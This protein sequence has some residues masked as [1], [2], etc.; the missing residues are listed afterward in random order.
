MTEGFK[1]QP[2]PKIALLSEGQEEKLLA[3]VKG[4]VLATVGPR[5]FRDDLPHFQPDEAGRIVE[6]LEQR[7][8]K[9][10]REPRIR[11]W[12]DGKRIPMKD[13]VQD[14]IIQGIMGMLGT[15]KGFIPARRVDITLAPE[16]PPS[17]DGAQ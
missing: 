12:L 4:V 14:I 16:A 15:L 1:K 2:F 8:L 13:F 6:M 10:H 3:E 9:E 17:E 11:V 7:F 5:P